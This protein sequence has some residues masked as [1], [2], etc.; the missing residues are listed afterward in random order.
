LD[1]ESFVARAP[2]EVVAQEKQR[3]AGFEQNH[4]KLVAQLERLK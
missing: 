3:L 2:V 4:E 1:N